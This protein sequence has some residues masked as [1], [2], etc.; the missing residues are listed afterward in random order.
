MIAEIIQR[1]YASAEVLRAQLD[2]MTRQRDAWQRLCDKA[3]DMNIRLLDKM[4]DN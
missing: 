3:Q 4:A 1:E 2:E